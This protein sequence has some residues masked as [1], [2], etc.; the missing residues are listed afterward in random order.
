MSDRRYLKKRGRR[1]YFQL[2]VPRALQDRVGKKVLLEALGTEVLADAQNLRWR[3]LAAAQQRFD[4][5]EEPDEDGL[6][7]AVIEREAQAT[8]KRLLREAHA[9]A[10]RGEPL[11]WTGIDASGQVAASQGWDEG[12]GLEHAAAVYSEALAQDDYGLVAVEA[13]AIIKSFGADISA[14][15]EE[16]RE[17]CRSQLAANLEA[18]RARLAQLRS[19]PYEAPERLT[20]P[21]PSRRTR[22]GSPTRDM[23][24]PTIRRE[25][26]GGTTATISQVAKRCIDDNR[27][28]RRSRWTNQTRQQYETTYRLLSEFL[29]DMPIADVTRSDAVRFIE[30]LAALD[31]RWSRSPGARSASVWELLENHSG[32]VGLSAKTVNRYVASCSALFRWARQ[33]GLYGGANPFAELYQQ[34]DGGSG[35]GTRRGYQAFSIDELNRL[36][37]APLFTA[38]PWG[39]HLQPRQHSVQT[40]LAWASLIALFSGL[41][42]N[43]ICQLRL[44]DIRQEGDTWVFAVNSRHGGGR[45]RLVPIHSML[46]RCGLPD[47]LAAGQEQ[48]N[49]L[50]FPALRPGGPDGKHNW[51][52]T[53]AFRTLRVQQGLVRR[54][55]QGR[56]G[57]QSF[58]TTVRAALARANVGEHLAIQLLGHERADDGRLPYRLATDL[59]AVTEAVEA[60]HYPGLVL[61]HLMAAAA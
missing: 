21:R 1:W 44:N 14:D 15:E 16:Y 30:A 35:A 4:A 23:A 13:Q 52:F 24:A 43:E 57:F 47:Y 29:A 32:P 6:T 38:T 31:P 34:P 41:R 33:H 8:M 46:A 17:L 36:F 22:S 12:A 50:L 59:R 51:Y 58:R 56:L 10:R 55:G 9:A 5:L 54:A 26:T 11:Q 28:N 48:T 18:V 53:S 61:D 37:T 20:T 19:R 2:A 39:A 40:A 42:S 49:G 7:R 3:H 45:Q 25:G 27:T 60:I